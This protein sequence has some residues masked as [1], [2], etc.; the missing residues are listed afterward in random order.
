LKLFTLGL[1]CLPPGSSYH[2]K[3]ALYRGVDISRSA[4]FKAKYDPHA[5]P[6]NFTASVY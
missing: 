1:R 3:G 5:T 4:A 6:N 2:F